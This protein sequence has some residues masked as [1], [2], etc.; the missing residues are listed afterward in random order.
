MKKPDNKAPKHLNG[1]IDIRQMELGDLPVCF[2]IGEEIFTAEKWPNLYRTWDE[3]ELLDSYASESE[4]CLV[5]EIDGKIAGFALGTMI[6]KRRSAWMY[7]YLKWIG[8]RPDI[9]RSGIGTKLFDRLTEL[10]IERGARMMLVDTEAENHEAIQFF[11][12]QGF[13]QEIKHIYLSRNLSSHPGYLKRK[14]VLRKL[15]KGE[16]R[17]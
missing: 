11:R 5:A 6:E 16:I 14:A 3:Y 12:K 4:L 15:K 2:S 13:G 17:N 10:F 8:V 7:G 9:K 1:E